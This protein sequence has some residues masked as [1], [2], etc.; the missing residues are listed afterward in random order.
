MSTVQEIQAA[1]L[2]L[3]PQDRDALRHWLDDTEEET[4][5]ILAAIDVGHP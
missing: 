5:E 2:E 3:A 4:P 1:I